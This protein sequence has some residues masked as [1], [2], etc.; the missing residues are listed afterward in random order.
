MHVQ[1][2]KNNIDEGGALDFLFRL[3]HR[4]ALPRLDAPVS[5]VLQ[6]PKPVPSLS[7]IDFISSYLEYEIYISYVITVYNTRN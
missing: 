1:H 5:S 6:S 2:Y 7:W 4:W 3:T